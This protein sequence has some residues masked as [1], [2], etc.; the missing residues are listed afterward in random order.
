MTIKRGR[1]L[2]GGVAKFTVLFDFY[3]MLNWDNIGHIL[4][5]VVE[6]E[7]PMDNTREMAISR[8]KKRSS[9]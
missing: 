4:W 8:R 2:R 5:P 9:R 6:G 1:K 7:N 3:S